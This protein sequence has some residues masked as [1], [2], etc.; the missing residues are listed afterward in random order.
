MDKQS[1][2]ILT[3]VWKHSGINGSVWT[4][5]ISNIGKDSQKF[6]EGAPRPTEELQLPAVD[7]THDWYWTPA[8]STGG[9]KREDFPSQRVLWVDCDGE[10][11]NDLLMQLKPT[12]VWE[13][14]PGNKQAIWLLTDYIEPTEFHKDG[15]VGLIT[16]AIGAD[17]SGVDIGQLLRI[18]ATVHH[19][20]QPYTGKVLH[21]GRTKHSRGGLITQL[22]VKLGYSRYLASELGSDDPYGDRSKM[23]WKMERTA[24][25]LQ[26]DK[27]LTYKLLKACKWNK[28]RDDP[29]RLRED[30]DK[31][32]KATPATEPASLPDKSVNISSGSPQSSE[33]DEAEQQPTPWDM[34]TVGEF[35]EVL[36]R[37]LRWVVPNVIPDSGCGLLIASPKVGKTR[38][39]I[40]AALGIATGTNPLGVKLNKP[41]PVGFMSLEDGQYL[42]SKRLNDSLNAD[43]G[44]FAYHWDGHITPDMEW[45]PAKPMQL[46]S[47]FEQVD[48][49][50]AFDKQRLLET[51]VHYGLKL[52]I[53]DTLSMAVG[54]ADVNSSTEMYAILKDIKTIAKETGC[55]ILFIHHTRK[56]VFDKGESIHDRILGS[57]ALHAWSDFVLSLAAPEE[58]SDMLRL[59]VQ[60]KMATEDYLLDPNLKIVVK[61]S[62]EGMAQ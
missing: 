53:I 37:P 8:V 13:T 40:E 18:P 6:I 21:M 32:Y 59:G 43:E 17:K 26:L 54:K 7:T 16:H 60:T 41:L 15:L 46:L 39:A 51:I 48:L 12:Y 49:N 19:K 38:I 3:K 4:P 5:R 23:L 44:R 10:Y 28:W 55:A 34:Q 52:M 47:S 30:I 24:S 27:E 11:D 35:G 36:R 31:A 1:A 29:E 57:T 50:E 58:G 42:F 61:P 33:Q 2:R 20:K 22:A 14:S 25:E 56:R 62:T 9:R 45:H